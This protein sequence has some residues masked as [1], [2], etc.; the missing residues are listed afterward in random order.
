MFGKKKIKYEMV[1]FSEDDKYCITMLKGYDGYIV[2]VN[3]V[4][5]NRIAL[6][7]AVKMTE[8]EADCEYNKTCYMLGI[9]EKA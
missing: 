6:G 7:G 5:D 3:D 4:R 9:G 2:L 8:S 1:K